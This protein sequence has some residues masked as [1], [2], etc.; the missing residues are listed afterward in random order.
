[1]MTWRISLYITSPK[2]IT[3]NIE[4]KKMRMGCSF[5]IFI[6]LSI[7][8]KWSAKIVRLN[9]CW[10]F[11]LMQMH[12]ISQFLG[13]LVLSLEIIEETLYKYFWPISWK[14]KWIDDYFYFW[15]SLL[16]LKLAYP[17]NNFVH[18]YRTTYKIIWCIPSLLYYFVL[19]LIISLIS[20]KKI[21]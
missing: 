19:S 6:V 10:L 8:S 3:L 12:P 7:V 4:T 20:W 11:I 5:M 15:R 2:L 17:L 16:Y 13:F 14:R 21:N 9:Y 18:F 1:M